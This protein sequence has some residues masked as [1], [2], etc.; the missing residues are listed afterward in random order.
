MDPLLR[1]GE[2]V[3]VPQTQS[4][5]VNTHFVPDLSPEAR[6]RIATIGR[7][8]IRWFS[9]KNE[10]AA[11]GC[12]VQWLE[13]QNNASNSMILEAAA[14]AETLLSEVYWLMLQQPSGEAGPLA[15]NGWGNIFFVKDAADQLRAVYIHWCEDSWSI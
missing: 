10:Q 5:S 2:T 14:G 4:F 8:F 13:L 11:E 12:A 9:P 15:T 7:N 3:A 6:V 1:S